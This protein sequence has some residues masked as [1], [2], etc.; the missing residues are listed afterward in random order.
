MSQQRPALKNNNQLTMVAGRMRCATEGSERRQWERKKTT[1][2][3]RSTTKPIPLTKPV[4]RH[5]DD[6]KNEMIKYSTISL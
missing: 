1:G 2:G 6:N 5:D 4:G 3:R